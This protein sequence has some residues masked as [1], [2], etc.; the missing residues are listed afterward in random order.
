MAITVH[1]VRR[2]GPD[3]DMGRV[4]VVLPAYNEERRVA[5]TVGATLAAGVARVVCVND[6]SRDATG[7]II[8][9]LADDDR[10]T[11]RHHEV[12]LG[13]QAAVV[14]GLRAMLEYSAVE[15]GA[16]LDADMQ[17]DPALLPGLCPLVGPYDVVIGRRGRGDMPGARKLANLLAN[18]PYRLLAGINLTDVQSGYR[19]YSRQAAAYLARHMARGGRYTFEHTSMLLFGRLARERGREFRIAEVEIPYSYEDAASSI[20]PRD[21]AQLTW[22][23]IYNAFSL[24]RLQQ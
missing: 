5:E 8:D 18:L 24:A 10:V 2:P 6:C 1:Q 17:N 4:G 19:L 12:N 15:V 13:K 23:A 21:N 3:G 16:V 9:E 11:A 20:R 14:S 7:R 22:A